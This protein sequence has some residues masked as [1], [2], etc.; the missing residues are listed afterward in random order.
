MTVPQALEWM[1][2]ALTAIQDDIG[3]IQGILTD[4]EVH[5][6]DE[7]GNE[8][9]TAAA[10]GA[11]DSGHTVAGDMAAIATQLVGS[12]SYTTT[13]TVLST[14]GAPLQGVSVRVTS[15]AAGNNTVAG[16]KTTDVF[17]NAVFDL[18]PGT[19]RVWRQLAGANFENPQTIVVTGA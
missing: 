15:D 14:A 6:V 9:A 5:A 16:P 11:P 3:T 4:G 2:N 7:N 1:A 19:F 13:I 17:G 8:L 12:G 10:L 18:P